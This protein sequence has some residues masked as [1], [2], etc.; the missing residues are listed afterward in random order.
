MITEGNK[1]KR[2]SNSA[3]AFSLLRFY[4]NLLKLE[5]NEKKPETLISLNFPVER[6]KVVYYPSTNA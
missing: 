2:Q 6:R 3:P 1:Q 5:V 4:M